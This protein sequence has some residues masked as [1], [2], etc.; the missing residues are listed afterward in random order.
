MLTESEVIEA[1]CA[2]LTDKGFRVTQRLSEKQTGVDIVAVAPNTGR[3][4]TIEAKGETS[5][6]KHTKR[7]GKT[8][9]TGQVISH[10]SRAIY[11][12]LRDVSADLQ[13]G[14]ALPRNDAHVAC[15]QKILPALK[16]LGIEVFWVL[17]DKTVQSENIWK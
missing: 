13:T 16:K 5:S 7:Y 15:V 9:N 17:P 2:F 14:I 10:V 1:V 11:C 6:Q 4:V 12:G 8:F 3:K